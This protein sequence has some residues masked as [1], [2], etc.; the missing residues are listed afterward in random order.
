[1]S[2]QR[3]DNDILCGIDYLAYGS[4]YSQVSVFGYL[5]CQDV[6]LAKKEENKTV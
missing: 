4:E 1:M 2:M 3:A 6:F 5:L